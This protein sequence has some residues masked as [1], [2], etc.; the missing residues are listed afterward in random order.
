MKSGRLL[1][2]GARA[3]PHAAWAA[4]VP[5]TFCVCVFWMAPGPSGENRPAALTR[6]P[7]RA[8][9]GVGIFNV[10]VEKLKT[11][12]GENERARRLHQKDKNYPKLLR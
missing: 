7:R 5:H 11:K 10:G 1:L 2:Q 9:R 6:G 3:V 8:P 4:T 12:V